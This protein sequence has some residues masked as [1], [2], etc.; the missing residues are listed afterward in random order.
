MFRF[1][2]R[3]AEPCNRLFPVGSL[4]GYCALTSVANSFTGAKTE[5]AFFKEETTKNFGTAK[6]AGIGPKNYY[7]EKLK[8]NQNKNS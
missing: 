4:A 1:H 2:R 3:N 6:D 7:P 8:E 5:F